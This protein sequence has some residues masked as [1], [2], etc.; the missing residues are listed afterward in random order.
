MAGGGFIS[1]LAESPDGTLIAGGGTQGFFRS[2]DGGLAWTPQSDGLPAPAYH[3][4]ALLDQGST[5]YAAVGDG[6]N[7]GIATSADNGLTWSL[8]SHAGT[9]TPPVF[10]GTNLPRQQGQPRATGD[11]LASDGTYLHAASFGQGL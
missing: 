9:G 4:A 10:D 7:E 2:T 11:L 1:V 8:A 6:S 5:W 3:V